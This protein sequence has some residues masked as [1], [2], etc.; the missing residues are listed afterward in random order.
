MV[1]EDWVV[2]ILLWGNPQ[3]CSD[4]GMADKQL[5]ASYVSSVSHRLAWYLDQ[6]SAYGADPT[7]VDCL[8][9][10]QHWDPRRVCA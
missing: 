10:S 8:A 1:R 4:D 9:G 6:T 2:V 7:R 5:A 3:C